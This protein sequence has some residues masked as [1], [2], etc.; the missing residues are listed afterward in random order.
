[1]SKIPSTP[2][3][4]R[5]K[6]PSTTMFWPVDEAGQVGAEED[7]HVSDVLGFADPPDGRPRLEA[8]GPDSGMNSNIWAVMVVRIIPGETALTRI[9]GAYSRAADAVRAATAALLAA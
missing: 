4:C 1:M 2:E 3:P 7:D 8:L 6:P 9:D 5:V